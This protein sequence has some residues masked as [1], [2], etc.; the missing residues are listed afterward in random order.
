MNVLFGVAEN[1]VEATKCS[2]A[3]AETA[4]LGVAD[5]AYSQDDLIEAMATE[6]NLA[7][8][9]HRFIVETEKALTAMK[10]LRARIV[11]QHVMLTELK[12]SKVE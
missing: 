8:T 4:T 2:I 3:I 7:A 1:V 5:C 6:P 11:A 12:P 9:M 10:A